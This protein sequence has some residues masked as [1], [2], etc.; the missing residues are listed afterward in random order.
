MRVKISDQLERRIERVYQLAGY[1]R[2][3]DL[4]REAT[5]S[6]L[7]ELETKYLTH[8][9]SVRDA[10]SHTIDRG[11]VGSPEIRLTPTPDAPVRF[12]YVYVGDPP[13]TTILDTGQAFIPEETSDRSDIPGIKDT[14]EAID[15]VDRVDVL[16]EGAISVKVTAN[17]PIPVV[18]TDGADSLVDRIY[19]PLL[20]LI[21]D[22]NQSVREGELTRAEARR[23]ATK[24]YGL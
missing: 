2:K 18:E 22:A 7:D 11:G 3:G 8:E 19:D 17:T 20:E 13:H 9:Q 15:G 5:R 6:R 21:T 14:L 16:T 12:E 4:I 10:F 24:G 1:S 23:Q